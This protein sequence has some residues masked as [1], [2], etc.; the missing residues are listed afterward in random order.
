MALSRLRASWTTAAR[1]GRLGLA[2]WA[3]A[4][5]AT[6]LAQTEAA[7][8]QASPTEYQLKAVF[9]F[10]FA[11]FAEWP[12][13]AFAA[14][15][16]PLII[17]ILGKDP[18]GAALDQT[19]QGETLNGHPLV[20]RRYSRLDEIPTCHILFVNL[21]ERESVDSV[22]GRLQ[23]RPILTVSDGDRFTSRGGMIQFVMDRKRIRL[24]VNLDAANAA[25]VKLSSKLLRSAE[26]VTTGK[27][28]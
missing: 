27:D 12:E 24:R 13:A 4:G 22:L 19:V 2:L 3:A 23:Q 26:I 20:V 11:Q 8:A 1:R 9:L 14:P 17:G 6:V 10:N 7:T 18:F 16:S 5:A 28:E 21:P 15:D 25:H